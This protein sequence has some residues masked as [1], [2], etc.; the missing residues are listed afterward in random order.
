MPGKPHY[1]HVRDG[2]IKEG[3]SPQWVTSTKKPFYDS[4]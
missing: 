2:D 1:S 3:E 4:S